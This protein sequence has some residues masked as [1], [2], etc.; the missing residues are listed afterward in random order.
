MQ[1]TAY[2]QGFQKKN[3]SAFYVPCGA[4]RLN[5]VVSNA[6][7]VSM[8]ATGFFGNAGKM[9]KLFS[10]SP[11]SWAILK[12]HVNI[13]LESWNETRWESQVKVSNHYATKQTR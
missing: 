3:Q 1:K 12:M 11:Q 4:H 6:A 5:L 9:Y 8:D 7:K 13:T 10:G 2:R